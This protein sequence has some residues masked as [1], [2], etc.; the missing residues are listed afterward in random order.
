MRLRIRTRIFLSMVAVVGTFLG[1][2]LFANEALLARS[3]ER[4]VSTGLTRSREAILRFEEARGALLSNEARSLAQVPH[5]RAVLDIQDVDSETLNQAIAS[6]AAVSG[7]ALLV[8][9][10]QDGA[11]LSS[12]GGERWIGFD[13][14]AQ[15]HGAAVVRGEETRGIWRIRESC[16]RVATCPVVVGHSVV[17]TVCLGEPLDGSFADDLRAVTGHDITLVHDGEVLF[18]SWGDAARSASVSTSGRRPA[19]PDPDGSTRTI[20][21]DGDE[22]VAT[23]ASIEGEVLAVVSR[24][25]D[26]SL[27]KIRMAERWFL[28]AASAVALLGLFMSHFLA[29]Q[30]GRPIH[31][32]MRATRE[33]TQGRDVPAADLP[34]GGEIGQLGTAF[35]EMSTAIRAREAELL[36][37]RDRAQEASRAK[38]AFMANM[39]HE[40]RTPLHGILSF[41]SLGTSK[42]ATAERDRL[43]RYFER[44]EQSGTGLLS[45]LNN[46]LDLAKLESGGTR[47]TLD[48]IELTPLVR[49]VAAEFE[50]LLQSRGLT[51]DLVSETEDLRVHA[52]APKIAQ[53]VRNVL[54][55]ASRFTRE[56][57]SIDVQV[58][59]VEGAAVIRVR[60]EGPGIPDSE[61]DGIFDK[62]VQSSNT[63]TGAGGTGLGLA[64]CREILASHGGR[65]WAENVP[66]GVAFSIELP[67]T[68]KPVR[69][70][71]SDQAVATG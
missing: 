54:G 43:L 66:G 14:A 53:V 11:V 21:W 60:N 50:A 70:G 55:N 46:V 3:V 58:G 24:R 25:K 9:L 47:F 65:I 69:T 30:I 32:L 6:V 41:A 39:S 22:I 28:F 63:D 38:S 27:A 56:G 57:G 37:E 13:A 2:A 33:F 42:V 52:D 68:P 62:F 10:D 44:I 29:G 23:A 67:L 34:S 40:L 20:S 71:A 64:I 15:T 12:S 49:E 8:V 1:L 59:D 51:L 48:E 19:L 36:A 31:S 26:E 5:L 4:D 18:A 7:A 61:L 45:L 35:G 16:F 17:G